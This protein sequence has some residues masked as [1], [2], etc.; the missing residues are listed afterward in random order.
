MKSKI[1]MWITVI[2]LFAAGTMPVSLSAQEQEKVKEHHHHQYH[3]YQLIDPGTLGG[4]NS[5]NESNP[6]ENL[7]SV[8]GAA[9][10]AADTL[11]PDPFAPNCFNSDCFVSY[12]VV[13]QRGVLTDL[14]ALDPGYSSFASAINARGEVAGVSENGQID[15][16][17]AF[18]EIIA[19]LWKNGIINLGTLGGNQSVA[20]G[21]SDRGQVVGAALNA[22]SDPFATIPLCP[23][24]GTFAQYFNFVPAATQMHA[25][26]W[27][28]AGGM[29]DLGALGGPDSSAS[30][31]NQRGQ[32]AG[33]FFTSFTPNPS[34][35]VP[36]VDP[37]FWENGKMV[38]IG[39]LGGTFG[40]P[41]WMNN[42]G[43]VVG[44]SNVAGDQNS[45]A[46]R[47]DKK[48]GL[49]DL[50]VLPGAS[51]SG[52][53]SIN[54]AGE[55]VGGSCGLNGANFCLA[56]L[57]KDGAVI[58]LGTLA[59]D[60]CSSANW[61]NSQSQIVGF[62]SADCNNEDHAG[63]SENGGRFVDLQ[64]LVLPGSGVTLT[65]AIFINDQGEI[66]ARGV[67]SNGDQRAVVL[68]PCDEHHADDEGCDYSMV[69]AAT[70]QQS[71]APATQYPAAGTP[72]SRMP[73]GMSNHFRSRVGQRTPVSGNVSTPAA[74]QTSP[75]NTNS[76]DLEGEQLL[77]P[78]Y[79]RYK[80]YCGVNG[81]KLTGYCTAYSY[82]SCLA[83]VSTACP[84]GKT[85]TKPGYFRCSDRF[86]RYVDLGRSCNFN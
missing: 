79:G 83:K 70:L 80:G 1:S 19:V 12:A 75:A 72:R 22:I 33:E 27:T 17:T 76:V 36:T 41:N 50:G 24:C 60:T 55:I 54:D 42:R 77:G 30:F 63:L 71:E 34:T 64:K 45:H 28:E 73:A 68:I 44:Y 16:L 38:D 81:G 39:T 29:Q 74:E 11:V 82:Y 58:D 4:P 59:G 86:S 85:A 14:G 52:A 37:F 7:I 51:S 84:S 62:A 2:A 31:V 8:H 21:I 66:A 23:T 5:Y 20:N 56:V 35:G 69:D 49:K 47:W 6:I 48:E 61:I 32:I 9:A 57:W 78:L 43:Q 15:P 53:D 18:P 10:L 26:R 67:L 3:H 13:W 40:A 46:F 25:F 65:N